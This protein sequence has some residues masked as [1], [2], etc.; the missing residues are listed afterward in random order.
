MKKLLGIVVL[1]LLLSSNAYSEDKL[2]L[3]CDLIDRD[4]YK[5]K[6]NIDMDMEKKQLTV[7]IVDSSYW[8]I[9]DFSSLTDDSTIYAT[10]ILKNGDRGSIDR[11]D[12]YTEL[13]L[14]GYS[15]KGYC[16]I[17]KEKLF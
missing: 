11:Y 2:A 6:Y 16:K 8:N 17:Y 14:N 9:M 12:G 15:R 5:K 1:G 13:M 3:R 4:K 10:S 7:I